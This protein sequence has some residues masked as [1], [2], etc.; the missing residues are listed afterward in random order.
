MRRI[1][2][3]ADCGSRS[4]GKSM[5]GQVK[6]EGAGNISDQKTDEWA[7]SSMA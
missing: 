1:G 5:T 3:R 4:C 7:N 2:Q 6:F